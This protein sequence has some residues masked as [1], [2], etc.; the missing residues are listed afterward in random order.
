MVVVYEILECRHTD[1]VTGKIVFFIL[2]SKF[3]VV[4][5]VAR[6]FRIE[7]VKS[8]K[9]VYHELFTRKRKNPRRKVFLAT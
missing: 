5:V 2:S 6:L 7:Q 4:K 3:L 9:N 8:S 1:D